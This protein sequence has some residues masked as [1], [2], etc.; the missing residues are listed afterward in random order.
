MPTVL[1]VNGFR[2]FFYSNEGTEP[3][4]IHVEKGD[5]TGKWWLSDL[6][7][8]NQDDFTKADLRKIQELLVEHQKEFLDAWENHFGS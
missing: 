7:L 1:T 5:A 6:S 3:P 2:F 4:H 8:S